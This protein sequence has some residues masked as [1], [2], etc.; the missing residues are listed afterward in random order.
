VERGPARTGSRRPS[1]GGASTSQRARAPRGSASATRRA[2]RPTSSARSARRR[3][4]TSSAAAPRCSAT[5][6]PRAQPAPRTGAPPP[7]S[8]TVAPRARAARTQG[9]RTSPRALRA[10]ARVPRALS[11]RPSPPGTAA[12]RGAAPLR[13]R[14][15]CSRAGRGPW[16]RSPLVSGCTCHRPNTGQRCT[17]SA[18]CNATGF[19]VGA[20]AWPWPKPP[21]PTVSPTAPPTVPV[22]ASASA[23]WHRPVPRA[24]PATAA[25]RAPR[26][27]LCARAAA[28]PSGSERRHLRCWF[29]ARE[30]FV[31]TA[32]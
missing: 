10:A 20:L 23:R 6:A 24:R 9:A 13:R 1:A 30:P 3:T 32:A 14:A 26:R 21:S 8:A 11:R 25:P 28:A 7:S 16:T 12:A 19:C 15:L 5:T 18:D 31:H 27:R 22:R 17:R 2:P 4:G 29:R